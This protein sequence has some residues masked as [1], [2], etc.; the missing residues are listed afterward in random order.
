MKRWMMAL[1]LALGCVVGVWAQLPSSGVIRMEWQGLLNRAN[2]WT[3]LQTFDDVTVTGTC[4][5][6]GGLTVYSDGSDGDIVVDVDN[7]SIPDPTAIAVWQAVTAYAA[8]DLVKSTTSTVRVFRVVLSGVSGASEP[9]A[10][11][12][13]L[14]GTQRRQDLSDPDGSVFWEQATLIVNGYLEGPLYADDFTI[15]ALV[16]LRTYGWPIYARGTATIA[17]TLS[18]AGPSA[19]GATPGAYAAFAGDDMPTIFGRG[20]SGV[21]PAT[22]GV[23]GDTWGGGIGGF[24]GIGAD[25][26]TPVEP[27]F[28]GAANYLTRY[29]GA[30]H[31]LTTAITPAIFAIGVDDFTNRVGSSGGGGVSDTMSMRSGGA[32]GAAGSAL[33]LIARQILLS[34]VLTA[35]GGNGGNGEAGGNTGGGGGGSGGCIIL[36]YDTKTGAGTVDVSGGVGGSGQGTGTA[37]GSGSPGDVVEIVN[38][39]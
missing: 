29:R 16:T 11:F 35:K 20:T 6:C 38:V 31:N 1:V 39:V 32:S 27:G 33:A 3:A 15:A 17:G 7:I 18:A 26:P 25:S 13:G 2:T 36:A 5:G 34:G 23:I 9:F 22:V 12:N 8:G 4:A 19:I 37:G 24:G 10:F 21:A 28:Y 30:R 14:P